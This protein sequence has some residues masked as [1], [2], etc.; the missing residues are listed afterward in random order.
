MLG[1]RGSKLACDFVCYLRLEFVEA[2]FMPLDDS[3]IEL[4]LVGSAGIGHSL[5]PSLFER[6]Q[7]ECGR[8]AAVIEGS[9]EVRISPGEPG[10]GVRWA[11]YSGDRGEMISKPRLWSGRYDNYEA[12]RRN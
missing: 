2:F 10:G 9:C 1:G 4:E 7:S 11:W 12:T 8:A 5:G 6:L 3:S